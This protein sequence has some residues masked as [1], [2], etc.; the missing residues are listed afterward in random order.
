[1]RHGLPDEHE[2]RAPSWRQTV[3]WIP[4]VPRRGR[5]SVDHG[6][7]V[8]AVVAVLVVAAA[9]LGGRRERSA[10]DGDESLVASSA[11]DTLS[12]GSVYAAGGTIPRLVDLGADKCVP[13]KM[14][15]PILDEMRETFEGRLDVV[16]IDVWKD[17]EAG[18][19]YGV[20]VIPTQIFYDPAGNELFRHQG[21]LS[22]EDILA[23]WEEFGFDFDG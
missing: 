23:K 21:F 14:M 12:A 1:V 22:R 7:I 4:W 10:R 16:F 19:Q 2:E 13:C 8:V 17:P 20:K 6:A 11:S 3:T 18:R 15:A 5:S 9:L